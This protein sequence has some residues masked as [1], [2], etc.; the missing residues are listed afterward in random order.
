MFKWNDKFNLCI[1]YE[2]IGFM[3]ELEDNPKLE[4]D[5]LH[6]CLLAMIGGIA[7]AN[8]YAPCVYTTLDNVLITMAQDLNFKAKPK[9]RAGLMNGFNTLRKYGFI[10]M[11]EMFTGDKKQVVCVDFAELKHIVKNK[12][13]N[14]VEHIQIGRNELATIMKGSNVP[15]HLI[16]IMINYCSRFNISGYNLF[17]K[18]RPNMSL[19]NVNVSDYKGLST[20][21]SQE[22]STTTWANYFRQP[23]ERKNKW[24]VTQAMFSRYCTELV[25]L[26]VFGRLIVN[27][28]GRNLS[29]YFRPQHGDCVEWAIKMNTQQQTYMK[30]Q[31]QQTSTKDDELDK[32]LAKCGG[33]VDYD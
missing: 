4:V 25:T 29:Y 7:V 31:E 33:T 19:Y 12:D 13:G 20:W 5:D 11:N 2:V 17:S 22:I 21:I 10:K 16:T 23:I 30:E 8:P 9:V 32:I 14:T 28:Q 6:Y 1:D 27:E 24:E 15:H 3:S 26:G 18:W